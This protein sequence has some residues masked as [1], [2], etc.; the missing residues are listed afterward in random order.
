[1]RQHSLSRT[2]LIQMV[3]FFILQL[4]LSLFAAFVLHP[5]AGIIVFIFVVGMV[6][7]IN[8]M[9]S[10]DNRE[11]PYFRCDGCGNLYSESRKNNWKDYSLCRMCIRDN[12]SQKEF[13]VQFPMW[14]KR[15][16]KN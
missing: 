12:Q 14:L 6:P 5:V 4:A 3:F 15:L 9:V 16:R 8:D 2:D 1:M 13:A 10:K 11:S 7:F